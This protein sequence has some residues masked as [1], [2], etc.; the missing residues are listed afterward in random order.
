MKPGDKKKEDHSGGAVYVSKKRCFRDHRHCYPQQTKKS[1][2]PAPPAANK[3]NKKQQRNV[4]VGGKEVG[5]AKEK[6]GATETPH[7]MPGT[8]MLSISTF[9]N[10]DCFFDSVGLCL[11]FDKVAKNDA[12]RKQVCTQLRHMVAECVL[13][14][15]DAT[16][17]HVV[18][19]WLQNSDYYP[20]AKHYKNVLAKIY[21]AE[22]EKMAAF[23]EDHFLKQKDTTFAEDRDPRKVLYSIL[24]NP[25]L[26]WGDEVSILVL[27]KK[28]G[29]SILVVKTDAVAAA[30]GS[31]KFFSG[32]KAYVAQQQVTPLLTP[33]HK[34]NKDS[35]KYIILL[36]EN[37]HYTPLLF[38][39]VDSA[40]GEA[41]LLYH[42]KEELPEAI[43]HVFKDQ[44]LS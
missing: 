11:F 19:S 13:N 29:I 16:M 9:G 35:K 27:E 26:Y 6:S 22:H 34:K 2:I 42:S 10:G 8:S 3:V 14:K 37:N 23:L 7:K 30:S 31:N 1:A 41:K 17:N 33:L 39:D 38:R 36:L 44:Q 20:F 24:M 5:E 18:V 15:S 12:A 4:S 32:G 28:F 21:G 43:R 40:K 25:A